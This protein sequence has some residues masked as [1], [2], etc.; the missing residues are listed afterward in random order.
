MA[1]ADAFD[2]ARHCAVF[3]NSDSADSTALATFYCNERGI[4]Y[5]NRKGFAMGSA[6]AWGGEDWLAIFTEA[7]EHCDSIDAQHIGVCAGSPNTITV[8]DDGDV[9]RPISL[10]VAFSLCKRIRDAGK[11]LRSLPGG[12][13]DNNIGLDPGTG[14]GSDELTGGSP[15]TDFP[16]VVEAYSDPDYQ[17]VLVGGTHSLT[18]TFLRFKS[19][20]RWQ[21]QDKLPGGLIG[22]Q[23][24]P[25]ASHDAS[26]LAKSKLIIQRAVQSETP[27]ASARSKPIV[28]GITGYTALSGYFPPARTALIVKKFANAGFTNLIYWRQNGTAT[29]SAET[30]L[31][32]SPQSWNNLDLEA[33]TVTPFEGWMFFGQGFKNYADCAEATWLSQCLPQTGALHIGGW[34]DH[35]LWAGARQE[36]AS[37]SK[38]GVGGIGSPTNCAHITAFEALRQT[39]FAMALLAGRTLAEAAFLTHPQRQYAVGDPLYRPIR[40]S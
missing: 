12:S 19:G 14:G 20:F 23:T 24:W 10:L 6:Q 22:L 31:A 18:E 11:A 27:I 32:P 8:P 17:A 15:E 33:G 3:Y 36:L 5:A 28:V 35:V 40:P 39:D 38:G 26:L 9:D 25:N 34:S 30:A 16:N 21:D 7:A 29:D 4:P 2:A 13:G 37:N 1:V